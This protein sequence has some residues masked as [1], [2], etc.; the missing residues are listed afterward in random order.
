MQ[1]AG[2]V[3]EK[4][5]S[6]KQQQY[7]CLHSNS[8]ESNYEALATPKACNFYW[9]QSPNQYAHVGTLDKIAAAVCC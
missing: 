8:Q 9:L 5:W 6:L 2:C 1:V 7:R 3:F 4:N